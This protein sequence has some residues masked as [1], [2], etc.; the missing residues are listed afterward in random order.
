MKDAVEGQELSEDNSA[1]L[2]LF[3]SEDPAGTVEPERIEG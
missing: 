3:R 2:A 1:I